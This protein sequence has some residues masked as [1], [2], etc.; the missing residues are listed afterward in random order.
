MR[1][2]VSVLSVL[3]LAAGAS[4]QTGNLYMTQFGGSQA[5]IVTGG[6]VVTNWSTTNSTETGIAINGDVRIVGA[7]QNTNG[8]LY[9][10]GGNVVSPNIYTNNSPPVDSLYDGTTDGTFHYAVGHND[11]N[12]NFAVFRYDQN[13]QNGQLL[14]VPGNR[15]SGITYDNVNNSLWI[16][17]TTGFCNQIEQYDLNGNFM[18]SF[19]VA[20][21]GGYAIAYDY[22]DGTLWIPESFGQQGS[23]WNYDTGGNLIQQIFVNGLQGNPFGAEFDYAT[24][25]APGA[26][27]IL[28]LGG[29]VAGRRRR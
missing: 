7:F 26:G 23:L 5:T 14:F 8:S 11:F 1:R 12:S 19:P 25:P 29:I 4:A 21:P 13:W 10:L 20:I 9:D 3:A 18:S 22:T 24:I 15:S 28:A 27:A 16:T 2:S 6:S 17:N